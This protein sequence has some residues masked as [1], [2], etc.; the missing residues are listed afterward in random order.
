MSSMPA[1]DLAA[2]MAAARKRLADQTAKAIRDARVVAIRAAVRP[3]ATR[4][5]I[6]DLARSFYPRLSDEL[7]GEALALV[8]AD[9]KDPPAPPP[10]EEAPSAEAAPADDATTEAAPA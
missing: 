2:E 1:I 4:Q 10:A 7:L 8:Y 3:G 9:R 6:E 5:D